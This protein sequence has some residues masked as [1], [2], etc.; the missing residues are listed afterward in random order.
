MRRF[1]FTACALSQN[2]GPALLGA[3]KGDTSP[4]DQ[5]PAANNVVNHQ[6]EEPDG[7][8]RFQPRQQCLR[9]GQIADG[10][11]QRRQQRRGQQ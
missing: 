8:R 4:L 5:H 11:G 9:G 1:F 2:I 6:Q 10:G 7:H 3:V